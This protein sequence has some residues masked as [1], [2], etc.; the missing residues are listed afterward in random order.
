MTPTIYLE[1]NP[2]SKESNSSLSALFSGIGLDTCNQKYQ[3]RLNSEPQQ[4]VLGV[5][6][7]LPGVSPIPTCA[8]KIILT[9]FA[10]SPMESV[11][12]LPFVFFTIRTI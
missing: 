11:I 8:S 1:S 9:S 12:G 6:R 5:G 10:P 7:V 3:L 2:G 4:Q